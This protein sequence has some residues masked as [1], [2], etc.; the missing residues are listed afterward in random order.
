M[1]EHFQQLKGDI[2]SSGFQGQERQWIPFPALVLLFQQLRRGS[3][4]S[5]EMG[6]KK[7]E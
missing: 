5:G 1:E 2:S 7:R 6:S 3:Q 4:S